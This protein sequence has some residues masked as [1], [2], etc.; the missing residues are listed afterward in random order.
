MGINEAVE[1][2]VPSPPAVP[3]FLTSFGVSHFFR[4]WHSEMLCQ[5][6]I[7]S[8]W[9]ITLSPLH[10]VLPFPLSM[11]YYPFPVPE[12]FPVCP[13]LSFPLRGDA[14]PNPRQG[15]AHRASTP[16]LSARRTG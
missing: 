5:M 11:E 12:P 1:D 6:M 4:G 14:V 3:L 8:P 2:P 9:I 7:Q 10:G 13:L 15:H 16:M